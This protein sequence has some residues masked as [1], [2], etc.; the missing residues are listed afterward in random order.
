M[1]LKYQVNDT[2][3]KIS[4]PLVTMVINLVP[5]LKCK[6]LVLLKTENKQHISI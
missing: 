4:T 3:I 2:M 5:L 1:D 6:Q